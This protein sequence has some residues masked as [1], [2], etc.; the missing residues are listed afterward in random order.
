MRNKIAKCMLWASQAVKRGSNFCFYSAD[1]RDRCT[2]I[3]YWSNSSFSVFFQVAGYLR[4][5]W[6][7]IKHVSNIR[8]SSRLLSEIQNQ[9]YC[10]SLEHQTEDIRYFSVN[11]T[12]KVDRRRTIISKS[13]NLSHTFSTNHPK[14]QKKIKNE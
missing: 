6:E 5:F 10:I 7:F 1:R 14:K 4:M 3:A 13:N 11:P 9:V 2:L 8:K 12:L